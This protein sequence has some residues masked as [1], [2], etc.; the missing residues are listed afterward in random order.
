MLQPHRACRPSWS[1]PSSFLLLFSSS[2]IRD[3]F[4][5][6]KFFHL[7]DYTWPPPRNCQV[8]CRDLVGPLEILLAWEDKNWMSIQ[9]FLSSK[10]ISVHMGRTAIRFF[11][12]HFTRHMRLAPLHTFFTLASPTICSSQTILFL[13]QQDNLILT[14]EGLD[15]KI[16]KIPLMT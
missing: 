16:N 10:Y 14:G 2:A 6:P 12:A 4:F 1:D 5:R 9:F 3:G 13:N 11:L 7:M 15:P 8:S